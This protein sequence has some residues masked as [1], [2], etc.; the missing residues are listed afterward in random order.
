[1]SM[2]EITTSERIIDCALEL[3][4]QRGFDNVTINDICNAV[5][6]T[7][8]TFYYHFKSKD[9]LLGKFY[10]KVYDLNKQSIS[11]LLSASNFWEQIWIIVGDYVDYTIQYGHEIL[12][13]V[14]KANLNEN[15]GTFSL[16]DALVQ[17]LL[18][19]IIKK[20]QEAGHVRNQSSPESLYEAT[21]H[22][23]IGIAVMW[24]IH[25]G[26]FDEKSIILSNLEALFDVPPEFSLINTTHGK[27]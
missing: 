8:R 21:C 20:A 13:Q 18:L 1:M 14:F 7:K 26:G 3:F 25:N 5:N 10:T 22:I 11:R 12:K 17:Q 24:C 9:D 6:I 15:K 19:P 16:E 4:K 2:N 23:V 27:K